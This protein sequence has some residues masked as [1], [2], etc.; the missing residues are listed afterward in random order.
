M[1]FNTRGQGVREPALS[2]RAHD[3]ATAAGDSVATSDL[4]LCL[5][6]EEGIL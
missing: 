3:A 5:D 6:K 1:E 2:A 4:T